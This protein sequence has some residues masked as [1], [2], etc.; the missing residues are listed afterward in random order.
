MEYSAGAKFSIIIARMTM[1]DWCTLI[2]TV[3]A[4]VAAIYAALA[5][6]R[7][8]EQAMGKQNSSV[9]LSRT[10]SLIPIMA[11]LVAWGAVAFNYVDRRYLYTLKETRIEFPPIESIY[12]AYPKIGNARNI[13]I[14]TSSYIEFHQ[15]GIVI[16]LEP[17]NKIIRLKIDKQNSAI[18]SDRNLSKGD[19]LFDDDKI[20]SELKLNCNGPRGG[21]FKLWKQNRTEWEDI[22]CRIWYCEPN[23]GTIQYQEFEHGYV[24]TGIPLYGTEHTF[25]SDIYIQN[26]VQQKMT[27]QQGIVGVWHKKSREY[28]FIGCNYKG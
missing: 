4:T 16:Y 15:N 14:A 1:T 2:S 7:P 26:D 13:Q 22:G 19:E 11:A 21:I 6:H 10:R 17:A 25:S 9:T 20:R 5:Y 12:E 28:P 24:I 18:F 3:A 8:K 27:T 23:N